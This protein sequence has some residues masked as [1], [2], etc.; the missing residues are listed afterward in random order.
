MIAEIIDLVS[1]RIYKHLSIDIKA[2]ANLTLRR[3]SNIVKGN[4]GNDLVMSFLWT[5]K[6][7]FY[8]T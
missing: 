7:S 2:S 5:L 4:D 1:L 3:F 8:L 6:I